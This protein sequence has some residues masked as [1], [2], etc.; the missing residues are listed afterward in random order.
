MRISVTIPEGSEL[1]SKLKFFN[2]HERSALVKMAL[3]KWFGSDN[4][5]IRATT[6]E[7]DTLPPEEAN[8]RLPPKKLEQVMGD[9]SD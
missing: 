9:F 5:I 7:K 2:K 3:T 1:E 6:D 8:I 4:F